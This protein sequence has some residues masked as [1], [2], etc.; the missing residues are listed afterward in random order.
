VSGRSVQVHGPQACTGITA[1]LDENG[2]LLV[3]TDAGR[4]TVQTGGLRARTQA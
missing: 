2:F 1:G 4:V 3:D